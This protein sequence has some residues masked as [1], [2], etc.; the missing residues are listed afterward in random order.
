MEKQI[1]PPLFQP[2]KFPSV[3]SRNRTVMAPRGTHFG[4]LNDEVTDRQ[5]R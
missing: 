5:I 3:T 4:N 2:V 1:T